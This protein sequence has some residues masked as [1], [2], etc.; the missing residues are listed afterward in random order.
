MFELLAVI[1]LGLDTSLP[2]AGAPAVSTSVRPADADTTT[3]IGDLYTITLTDTESMRMAAIEHVGPYWAMGAVLE[4]VRAA[5]SARGESGS[6]VVRHLDDPLATPPQKLRSEIGFV[7]RDGAELSAPFVVSE[8]PPELVARM[9]VPGPSRFS[10]RYYHSLRTW[11]LERGLAPTGP[12]IEL[13]HFSSDGAPEQSMRIQIVMPVCEPDRPSP[14]EEAA[15]VQPETPATGQI[16]HLDDADS[17][18]A[19]SRSPVPGAR[20]L[21][22]DPT[23][24]V[25]QHGATIRELIDARRFDDLAEQLLPNDLPASDPTRLWLREVVLRVNALARGVRK[26]FPCREGWLTPLAEALVRR[27]DAQRVPARGEAQLEHRTV[28]ELPAR[29]VGAEQRKA[30][31]RRLELLMARVGMR[32]IEPSDAENELAEVLQE[33]QNLLKTPQR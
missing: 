5:M 21:D 18:A 17:A 32:S 28:R 31:T 19:S 9:T 30:V 25:I 6:V 13:L 27:E 24:V 1:L 8:W 29:E 11:V 3:S 2:A 22:R 23:S 10:S 26:Q 15:S 4:Q 33:A 12:V 20:S 14:T 7:I 16:A